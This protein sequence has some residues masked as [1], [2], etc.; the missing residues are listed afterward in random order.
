MSKIIGRQLP[1]TCQVHHVNGDETDDKNSN[2]VVCQDSAYHHLLHNRA[3]AL[4]EC[5]DP[6]GVRCEYCSKFGVVGKDAMRVY[7]RGD[8]YTRASHIDCQLQ[9]NRA[10][11]RALGKPERG[12]RGIYMKAVT[13]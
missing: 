1:T 12:E 13:L 7:T 6:T 5:G 4:R 10:R 8:G 3:N 9:Y 2:L 11:R